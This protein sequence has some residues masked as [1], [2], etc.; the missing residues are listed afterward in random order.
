MLAIRYGRRAGF[1]AITSRMKTDLNTRPVASLTWKRKLLSKRT[2]RQPNPSPSPWR[3]DQSTS[4]SPSTSI[5]TSLQRVANSLWSWPSRKTL[6]VA[7]DLY[8]R[9]KV[10]TYPRTDS[11]YLPSDMTEKVNE[12]IET[13]GGIKEYTTHVKRLQSEGLRNTDRNFNDAKV[14]DHYAIV[15]TGVLPSEALPRTMPKLST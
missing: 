9:Y 4:A 7:Q 14:S 3:S 8:D 5:L 15:P 12:I 2:L 11:Q 6:S 10:T 1:V 13:L